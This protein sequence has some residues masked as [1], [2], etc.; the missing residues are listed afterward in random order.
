MTL[1]ITEAA[2]SDRH[3]WNSAVA[4]LGASVFHRWEWRDI[5]K[6]T[7]GY[8]PLYLWAHED[9][10][11]CGIFPMFLW[12]KLGG[13]RLHSI[14][15]SDV[16]G[17]CGR[18]P[19]VEKALRTAMTQR[20]EKRP[21]QWFTLNEPPKKL[22]APWHASTPF[23]TFELDV[24][25]SYD[26]LLKTKVHQKTRNMVVRAEREGILVHTRPAPPALSAFYPLYSKTMR[27]LHAL[28]HPR[29]FFHSVARHLG[30][31]SVV[32]LAEQP[33]AAQTPYLAITA[34][35]WA[36]IH[37]NTLF[38]WANAS[39]PKHAHASAN[40]AVYAAALQYACEH[41]EIATVNFGS[42]LPDTPHHFFKKRWGGCERAIHK[43][44]TETTG[45]PGDQTAQRRVM[46]LLRRLP[47]PLLEPMARW[48]YRHY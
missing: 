41:P 3:A 20:V 11:V 23:V 26:E 36:F 31:N 22:E 16:G 25:T 45:N 39:D 13:Q 48:I 1:T 14:P 32:F 42:T 12:G 21:M 35:L 28:P 6:K 47:G 4:M 34:A 44:S 24:R 9:G 37:D 46:A 2:S 38:I 18:T 17:P 40:P 33:P 15:F 8:R 19:A 27:R 7:Y 43:I 10:A 29:L 30:E 5:F